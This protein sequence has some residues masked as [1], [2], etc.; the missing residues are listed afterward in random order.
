MF[1]RSDAKEVK[2][3]ADGSRDIAGYSLYSTRQHLLS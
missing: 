1:R 3:G 2:C